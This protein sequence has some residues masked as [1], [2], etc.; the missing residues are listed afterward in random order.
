VL[1]KFEDF[2]E[3]LNRVTSAPAKRAYGIHKFGK[4]EFREAYDFDFG[5]YGAKQILYNTILGQAVKLNS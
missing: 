2:C 3:Y 1:S 5:S 4:N